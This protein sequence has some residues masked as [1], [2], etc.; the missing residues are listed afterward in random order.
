MYLSI[1]FFLIYRFEVV[2]LVDVFDYLDYVFNFVFGRFDGNVYE[3][4]F[5]RV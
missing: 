3:D 2:C 4:F 5:E 1:F